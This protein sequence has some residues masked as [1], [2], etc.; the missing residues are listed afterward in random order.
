[1]VAL[2]KTAG[3]STSA[4]RRCTLLDALGE[5][6]NLLNRRNSS[7]CQSHA[8]RQNLNEALHGPMGLRSVKRHV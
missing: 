4:S 5:R 3:A 7:L 1:M 6:Q 8:A 2:F